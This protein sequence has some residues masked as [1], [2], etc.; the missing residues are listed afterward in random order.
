MT[1]YLIRRLIQLPIALIGLTFAVFILLSFSGDP[2]TLLM[3]DDASEADVQ[4]MRERLGLDQP[5]LYQ[6][7]RFLV[8]AVQGDFGTSFRLHEPAFDAVMRFFPA[9]LELALASLLIGTLI[10]LPLGF[11]AAVKRGTLIDTVATVFSV[12]GQSMP[13]FWI[14]IM[15]MLVFSVMLGWLPTS[16]RGGGD[17]MHLILPAGVLGWYIS[18]YLTRFVRAT[19]L[20]TLSEPYIRTARAK[21]LPERIVLFRHAFRNAQVPLLT[22]WGLEIGS[23]L[24]GTVVVET[25]FAWPGLGRAVV[26]AVGSRDYPVVL[27]AVT[28]F[29][30]TYIVIN[31]LI[32]IAYHWIDPRIRD[33]G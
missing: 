5:V 29:G 12:L 17:L 20:E 16:G 19:I 23:L 33:E 6:Y 21:G 18:A 26:M 4:R 31:F 10:A 28:V 9:T 2:A 11:L 22:I 7:W 30:V 27:A 15:A 32:D 25:V 24:T 3:P 13:V 14:G 1:S 8:G